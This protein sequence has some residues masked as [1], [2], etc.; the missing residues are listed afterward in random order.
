MK[1]PVD[2]YVRLRGKGGLG[3]DDAAILAGSLHGRLLTLRLVARMGMEY[4]D[5]DAWRQKD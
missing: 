1:I 2:V 5:G 3:G 4:P